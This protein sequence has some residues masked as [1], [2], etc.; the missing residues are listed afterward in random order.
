MPGQEQDGRVRA[1]PAEAAGVLPVGAAAHAVPGLV[2]HAVDTSDLVVRC[3]DV[4]ILTL[5]VLET[6]DEE[7]V[8]VGEIALEVPE[9]PTERHSSCVVEVLV[10]RGISTDDH[11]Q[12]RYLPSA[13]GVVGIPVMAMLPLMFALRRLWVAGLDVLSGLCNLLAR[14]PSESERPVLVSLRSYR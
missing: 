12:G 3:L 8:L 14:E 5:E 11:G 2:R 6:Q 7:V 1:V 13:P 9:L 10:E 4:L